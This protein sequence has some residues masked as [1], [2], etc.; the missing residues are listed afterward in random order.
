[1]LIKACIGKTKAQGEMN[2]R[3]ICYYCFKKDGNIGPDKR[4]EITIFYALKLTQ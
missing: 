2:I 4:P 3:T 1:M